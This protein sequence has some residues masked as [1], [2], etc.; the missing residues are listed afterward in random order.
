[1]TRP[2][3]SLGTLIDQVSASADDPLDRLDK[4]VRTAGDL[5]TLGDQLVSHFVDAARATGASWA[6]IG[7]YLGGVSKQ[8]AQQRFSPDLAKFDFSRFTERARR[9]VVG[10][11]S[12]A[13]QHEHSYIG[14]EHLLLGLCA[15][16]DSLAGKALAQ[17]G[18]SLDAVRTATE[19]R[20]AGPSPVQAKPRFTVKGRAALARA[21]SEALDLGHNYIGTEHLLLGL[22]AGGGTNDEP[23]LAMEILAALGIRYQALHD[24]LVEQLAGYQTK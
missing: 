19:G 12:V 14:T 2:Q 8:A 13:E 16:P 21:L 18:G 22:A 9:V 6:Q 3:V 10:A 20:L 24:N 1:M 4:A 23:S 7:Q 17:L 5:S 11:Q 15:D